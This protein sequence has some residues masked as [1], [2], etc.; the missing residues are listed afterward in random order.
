MQLKTPHGNI[1]VKLCRSPWSKATGLM[2][3]KPRKMLFEFS[4]PRRISLHMLFVFYPIDVYFLDK[5]LQVI[6][7]KRD[8]KPFTTHKSKQR[9]TYVL[10]TPFKSLLLQIGDKLE[11]SI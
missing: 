2:F 4:K 9:C 10:E 1:D 8:F 3:S 6:E 11:K 7:I 5:E